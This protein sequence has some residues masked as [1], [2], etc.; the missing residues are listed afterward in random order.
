MSPAIAAL[1][2]Q[3]LITYGPT[4]AKQINDI[5]KKTEITPADWD[6]VFAVI[7]KSYDD[8]VKPAVIA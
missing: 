3:A 6:K 4:V 1:I 7:E 2:L 8:Y 5:F